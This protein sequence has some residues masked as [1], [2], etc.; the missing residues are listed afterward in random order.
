MPVT[1]T[2]VIPPSMSDDELTCEL[3]SAASTVL[4]TLCL[5]DKRALCSEVRKLR[6]RW[7]RLTI[8]DCLAVLAVAGCQISSG[9]YF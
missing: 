3:A 5:E 2:Y 1:T 9:R 8:D 7:P 4:T 6:V